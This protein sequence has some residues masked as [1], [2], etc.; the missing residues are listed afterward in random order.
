MP[1]HTRLL[2]LFLI[3][4]HSCILIIP[5]NQSNFYFRENRIE[6]VSILEE[7]MKTHGTTFYNHTHHL[8]TFWS[9]IPTT[10]C[11][12]LTA[13]RFKTNLDWNPFTTICLM[14]L[15]S[16]SLGFTISKKKTGGFWR[17]DMV[18]EHFLLPVAN[19][20][21]SVHV[22]LFL[23]CWVWVWTPIKH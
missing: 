22:L 3:E 14:H 1:N 2:L 13:P 17:M 18:S 7:L 5:F 23:S 19:E 20:G 6:E 15:N 9:V 4:F 21:H 8:H 11:C 10:Y 16:L 12:P